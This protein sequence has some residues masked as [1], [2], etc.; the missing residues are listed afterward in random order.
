M[1]ILCL[2]FVLTN[3]CVLPETKKKK[4]RDLSTMEEIHPIKKMEIGNLPSAEQGSGYLVEGSTI[5]L[6]IIDG[7]E[8][9]KV[10]NKIKRL[11]F[12]LE[13]ERKTSKA[14]EEKLSKL[15][16]AKEGVEKDYADTRKK[17]EERNKVLS[18]EIKAMELKLRKSETRA[19][20]AEQALNPLKKGLLKSQISETKAQQELY[21]LKIE[22]IKQVEE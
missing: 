11:E 18:D 21:K 13:A 4:S 17:L 15:Q 14:F 12:R 3:G 7:D 9:L 20:T 8:E 19:V 16:A 22:N 5:S 1:A 2:L 10:L 6:G